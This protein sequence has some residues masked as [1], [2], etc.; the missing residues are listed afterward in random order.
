MYYVY[1]LKS[2]VDGKMYIGYTKNLR[3]RLRE[4]QD[5]EVM[6]T[7]PRRPLELI[8]YEGYKSMEDAKRREGYLKTSQGKSSLRLML[9]DSLTGN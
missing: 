4:H 9:R 7:R 1:V 6:S 8:F 5:G 3:N 2:Q